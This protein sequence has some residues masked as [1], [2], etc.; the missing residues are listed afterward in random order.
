MIIARHGI[1]TRVILGGEEMRQEGVCVTRIRMKT[2][3]EVKLKYD[4]SQFTQH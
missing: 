2:S 1:N 3:S 4:I